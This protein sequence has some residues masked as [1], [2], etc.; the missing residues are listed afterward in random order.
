MKV[1]FDREKQWWDAKAPKEEQDIADE[2]INR[3][4]RWHSI[5]LCQRW[6]IFFVD[7]QA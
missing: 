5:I 1:D 6:V 4:L 7:N 3:A 2:A